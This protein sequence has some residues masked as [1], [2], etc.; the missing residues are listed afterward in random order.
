MLPEACRQHN[1]ARVSIDPQTCILFARNDFQ[2]LFNPL[3]PLRR[4][5]AEFSHKR[6]VT[7]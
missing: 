6:P 3:T 1:E 5:N 7:H 4:R 2:K